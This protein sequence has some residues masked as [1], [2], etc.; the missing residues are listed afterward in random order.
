MVNI[1]KKHYLILII[2][3]IAGSLFLSSC[4]ISDEAVDPAAWG[5]DCTVTYDALGGTI[6]T[7]GVR[8]TYYMTN[9]YLFKPVGTTNML[10]E[11]AKDGFILAGWYTAKEDIFDKDGKVAGYSFKSEDRWDFQL[12]RVQ[13][14]MTLYARWVPQGRVEYVDAETNEVRFTKNITADSPI[15]PLSGAVQNLIAK[16]GYTFYGYFQDEAGTIPY[17]FSNYVHQDLIPTNAGVYALIYEKYPQYFNKIEYVAPSDEEE[18]PQEEDTSYLFLNK[19]GYELT[20]DDEAALRQIREYKDEIYEDS[21]NYY[22]EN[23]ADT[24]VYLKYEQGSFIPISSPADLKRGNSYGFYPT[25]T[26]GNPIEGYVITKDIDF[27]GIVLDSVEEYSGQISGNGFTLKNITIRVNSRK[28]DNDKSKTIG[29][30]QSLNGASI[31]DL[32]FEDMNV[33][34][35]VNSGI[36][37]TVGALAAEARNT[38]LKNVHFTNLTIDTGRGDDGVATYKVGDLF[39]SQSNTKLENVSGTNITV[40]ASESAQVQLVL[41]QQE[42][43]VPEDP[44]SESEEDQEDS[45]EA[46]N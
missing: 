45:A 27:S 41:E 28:I 5:Y 25:D 38:E 20:T 19:M 40:N 10:I 34:M 36:P 1:K 18:I 16:T 29:L 6:N 13:K 37:V 21:I 33:T 39:A 42:V 4:A 11:P 15:Q 35:N 24:I 7:R 3:V 9:S 22:A 31:Q 2:I 12:D 46:E 23:T 44:T 8:E 32:N 43:E 14:D 26:S 30:F 17:E